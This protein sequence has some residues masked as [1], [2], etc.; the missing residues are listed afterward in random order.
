MTELAGLSRSEELCDTALVCGDGKVITSSLLLSPLIPWLSSLLDTVI[1]VDDYKTVILPREVSVSSVQLLVSLVTNNTRLSPSYTTA[2]LM[3]LKQVCSVLDCKPVLDLLAGVGL[4]VLESVKRKASSPLKRKVKHPRVSTAGSAIPGFASF[5]AGVKLEKTE[6]NADYVDSSG[7]VRLSSSDEMAMHY[8]LICEGKFK[9]YNQAITHYDVVHSLAAAL[10]CDMC[11]NTFRDMYSCVKHKHEIH[12]QFDVNFQCYLCK[13]VL[14]SRF[15]LGT[16]IKESHKAQY[17]QFSC[18]ACGMK[19]AAQYY[20][21]I[22]QKESHS[23]SANTCN[24]CNKT[25]SGKRYLTMHIK[26]NHEA[27]YSGGDDQALPP[28]KD[29]IYQSRSE[30]DFEDSNKTTGQTTTQSREYMKVMNR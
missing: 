29:K 20:L 14:Y 25:F 8:C 16:H 5:P 17:G 6:L 3:S 21:T 18:R 12:G 28:P 30:G 4:P 22:H 26:A 24:I 9:K 19:F 7:L 23:D 27:Q 15:R 13:E 1:R 10:S 2:Q 11:D